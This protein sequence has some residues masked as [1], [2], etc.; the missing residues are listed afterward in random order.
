MQKIFAES[1]LHVKQATGKQQF[2]VRPMKGGICSKVKVVSAK[3]GQ[4][5]WDPSGTAPSV[6]NS[7]QGEKPHKNPTP[8]ATQTRVRDPTRTLKGEAAGAIPYLLTG[9]LGKRQCAH[10][11]FL[12]GLWGC[13]DYFNTVISGQHACIKK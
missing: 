8:S 12:I 4:P 10:R 7:G 11:C 6:S 1:T 13:R 9:H 3:L 2:P 5:C